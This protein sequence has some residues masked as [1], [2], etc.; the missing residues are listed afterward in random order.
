MALQGV[1][2]FKADP[3]FNKRSDIV[4]I[5]PADKSEK[6]FLKKLGLIGETEQARTVLI[7][8][9]AIVVAKYLGKTSKDQLYA[10]IKNATSGCCGGGGCCGSSGC[11]PG[12]CCK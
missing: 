1:K 6:S 5:D 9:P 7:T 8:P 2:D 3:R 11:C 4:V 10:D 12:G